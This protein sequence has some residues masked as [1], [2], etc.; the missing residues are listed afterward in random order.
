MWKLNL[1]REGSELSEGP[2]ADE[3]KEASFFDKIICQVG[4]GGGGRQSREE[5]K[6]RCE[7]QD[8][9]KVELDRWNGYLTTQKPA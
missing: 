5:K 3:V 1:R 6:G 4:N 8:L 7:W 9:T 2:S